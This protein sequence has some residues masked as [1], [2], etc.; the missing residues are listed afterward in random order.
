[1]DIEEWRCVIKQLWVNERV[2]SL[3]WK[4][5]LWMWFDHVMWR[6]KILSLF[7][8]LQDWEDDNKVLG[9]SYMCLY[10]VDI[11]SHNTPLSRTHTTSIWHR[12][13][14]G[15]YKKNTFGFIHAIK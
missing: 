2:D 13:D 8:N 10:N 11:T 4:Y 5:V 12:P 6:N 3:L 7:G 1:M 14:I 9:S 15:L